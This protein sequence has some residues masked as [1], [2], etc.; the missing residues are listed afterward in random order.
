[1]HHQGSD[2]LLQLQVSAHRLH[3]EAARDSSG[4]KG[5][6]AVSLYGNLLYL[7]HNMENLRVTLH[8]TTSLY[9]TYYTLFN[10]GP[11]QFVNLF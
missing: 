5:I 2:A 10:C 3:R 1:M 9:Q 6:V 4:K 7:R 11:V 8:F